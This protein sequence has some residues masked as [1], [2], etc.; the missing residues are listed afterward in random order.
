MGSANKPN[1]SDIIRSYGHRL[2]SFIRGRV[3]SHEDAEDI[4]QDVWT[5]FTTV[6]DSEPIEQASAWLFKV[7]RNK[8]TDKHRK[9]QAGALEDYTYETDEG[10]VYLKEI[11]LSD[12]G[13]PETEHLRNV[14]WEQL[15][16]ALAELPEAQ[17][18][19][20]TWHELDDLSFEEIAERT[21]EK[22]NTLISRKRYAVLHLR[23]RLKIIYHEI[24]HQ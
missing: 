14:F 6:V 24:I 21:G 19:V 18:Q 2:F 4:A 10:E 7:A 13:D 9:K 3:Q 5:Q 20:F 16:E 1:I 22:I 8:I 12:S 23:E 17:R 11:L 15:F